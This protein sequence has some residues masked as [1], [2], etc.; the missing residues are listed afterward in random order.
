M[1]D[2]AAP[3]D[4]DD[5]A[6][7]VGEGGEQ[8]EDEDQQRAKDEQAWRAKM[9]NDGG[10]TASDRIALHAQ[11]M[12]Q[13]AAGM[14]AMSNALIRRGAAGVVIVADS[15]ADSGASPE[16]DALRRERESA[17]RAALIDLPIVYREAVILCDMEGMS[18]EET[19]AAL[20]VSLGTVKS[21]LNRARNA[22]AEIIEPGLG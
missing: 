18:Y 11:A 22:F 14:T 17:L 13:R 15:I 7:G 3:D 8:Q 21:R 10:S 5:A 9:W 16:D 1:A 20:D 6:V 19:A 4:A 2:L 12:E